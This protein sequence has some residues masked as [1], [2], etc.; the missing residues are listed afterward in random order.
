MDF[1]LVSITALSLILA[2]AMGVVLFTVLREDR[3]RSDARVATLV[4]ASAQF[5]L[6]LASRSAELLRDPDQIVPTATDLFAVSAEPSPWLRRLGVAA[7]LTVVIG[8]VGYVLLPA[9]TAAPSAAAAASPAVPLELLAL[10]HTQ[11]PSGLTISGTVYNP[12]G[13]TPVSQVF[14]AAVLFGPD[15]NFLTS[16]RAPL[17]FTTLRPG[18]ESPFVITIPVAGTVARYRVG[19]RA[20]DGSVIAHVDRRADATAA[21]NAPSGGTPWPH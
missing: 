6:P 5:D 20:A 2:L 1:V 12:R 7:A 11:Q 21:Q 10:S 4:A 8:A 15:G 13:A 18:E 17:D 14:A 3:Q 19:F 9:K 16:S